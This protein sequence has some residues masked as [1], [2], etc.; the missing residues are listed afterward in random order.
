MMNILLIGYRCTGKSTVA[1]L[2]AERLHRD[3]I[4]ADRE[5]ERRRGQTIAEIFAEI[6]ES[7]FREIETS[8]VIDLTQRSQQII[9]LGGGAILRAK[10]RD[11]I[12]AGGAVFWLQASPE[13]I[14]H[15]LD[16]NS[17]KHRTAKT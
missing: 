16:W 2:V 5:I 13:T 1:R 10:N 9:A 8:V 12:R 6:G 15:R 17:A 3:W 14:A 11:A 7:G 4:D